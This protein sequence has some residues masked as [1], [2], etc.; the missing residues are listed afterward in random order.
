M[1]T[2]K[3]RRTKTR[4]GGRP[5]RL[6]QEEHA[7]ASTYGTRA[8]RPPTRKGRCE[9]PHESAPVHLPSQP[10]QDG[11]YRKPDASVTAST[12]AKPPQGTQPKTQARGTRQ[13]EPQRGALNG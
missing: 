10:L 4:P 1:A 3:V 7:Q 5:A 12:H 8:W 13:G 11:P 9:G 2:E 6:G